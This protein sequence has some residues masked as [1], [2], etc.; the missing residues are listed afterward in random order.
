MFMPFWLV[1]SACPAKL[2]MAFRLLRLDVTPRMAVGTDGVELKPMKRMTAVPLGAVSPN[3][4]F[5][6]LK[7]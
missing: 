6:W 2:Y 3:M 1:V 4:V 5:P 7:L